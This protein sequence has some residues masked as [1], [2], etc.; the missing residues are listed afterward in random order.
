MKGTDIISTWS[1]DDSST[2]T[3]SGTSMST[4]HVAGMV[5]YY[6][7]M[8]NVST[9]EMGRMLRDTATQGVLEVGNGSP[10]LLA[11][12]LLSLLS[13]SRLDEMVGLICTRANGGTTRLGLRRRPSTSKTI[14]FATV[15]SP[16][17]VLVARV[18]NLSPRREPHRP[19]RIMMRP[20]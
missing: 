15:D 19:L 7:S 5:A 16:S 20:T 18:G 14:A 12:V 6:L 13:R 11:Y 8:R 9:E 4:P 10:N 17:R 3:L 2:R 1:D